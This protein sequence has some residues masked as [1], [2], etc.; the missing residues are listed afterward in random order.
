MK[1][2]AAVSKYGTLDYKFERLPSK[3]KPW[4]KYAFEFIRVTRLKTPR[5]IYGN[6]VLKCFMM[7]NDP[8]NSFEI[9]FFKPREP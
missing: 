9:E 4:Y 6:N 3:L 8:L 5:I 2:V 7:E 1:S